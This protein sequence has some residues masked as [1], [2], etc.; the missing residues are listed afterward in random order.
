MPNPHWMLYGAYGYTGTLLAEEAVRRGHRP[1]LAGRNAAKLEPL[2]RRL[3]LDYVAF[4]LQDEARSV[5]NLAAVELVLHA[6]GPFVLTSTPMQRACLVSGTSYLDITG[7]I[8]VFEQTFGQ[9]EVARKRKIALISGAGFDVIPSDCLAR[10]VAERV[11]GA[12]ELETGIAA[13]ARASAGTAKSM[14]EIFAAGGLVRRAGVLQPFPL[15]A[16]LRRI[17]FAHGEH[18]ALPIPWGDLST[19]YRT[20]GIPNITTYLAVPPGSIPMLQVMLPLSRPWL[21][22]TPLRRWL[23]QVIAWTTAGPDANFR[24]QGRSYLWARATDASGH[25]AEAW[26]ETLEAYKFTALAGVRCVERVLAERPVGA[27]APAQVLGA[28]FVLE[29]EGTTRSDG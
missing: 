21:A 6:A 26:L 4:D 9:D 17:R 22:F 29:I 2:A 8:P 25:A 13:V 24:E 27:L 11:P 28:D 16:G 19:A 15:G 7:E 14:L 3:G 20:T 1:L 18:L 10:Y 12:V 23:Q 5:Q